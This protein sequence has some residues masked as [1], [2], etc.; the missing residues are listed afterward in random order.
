L[1]RGGSLTTVLWAFSGCDT[2]TGPG[3]S[4]EKAI[5][6]FSFTLGSTVYPGTITGTDIAVSLPY[7]TDRTNLIPDITVSGKAAVSP[8]SGAARDFTS[9]V[10]YTVTAEDGTTAEY[11]VTVVFFTC[12]GVTISPPETTGTIE[13]VGTTAASFVKAGTSVTLSASVQGENKPPQTVTWTITSTGHTPGTAINPNTGVLTIAAAEPHGTAITVTAVS[14]AD[15]GVSD[16]ARFTAVSAM[17]SDFYGTWEYSET[18]SGAFVTY[19]ADSVRVATPDVYY[20][21]TG[22]SWEPVSNDDPATRAEY[23]AGFKISGTVSESTYPSWPVGATWGANWKYFLK[24]DKSA[25]LYQ[26]SDPD[27]GSV[28]NYYYTKTGA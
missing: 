6:G 8:L 26:E 24:N 18:G 10:T 21:V 3:K 2:P 20:V 7:G 16:T 27:D 13:T 14:A 12:T 4:G 28:S 15:T 5:T 22:L 23:P 11:T 25:I 17:P 19:S 9:P 1:P